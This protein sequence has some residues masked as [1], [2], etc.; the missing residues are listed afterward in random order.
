MEESKLDALYC[1]INSSR[2]IIRVSWLK[3]T[4]VSG[5]ISIPSGPAIT[6]VP[7]DGDRDGPWNVSNF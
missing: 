4:Y 7:D 5:A 3:T 2:A 6:L 1:V